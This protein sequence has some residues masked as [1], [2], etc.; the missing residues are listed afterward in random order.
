MN[1]LTHNNHTITLNKEAWWDTLSRFIDVLKIN[2]FIIDP[3]GQLILPPDEGRFGGK[4]FFDPSLKNEF[5]TQQGFLALFQR[6]EGM[7]EHKNRF[8]LYSYALP[9][10][11]DDKNI[12]G[13]LIVG[14]IFISKKLPSSDYETMAKEFGIQLQDL[15]NIF[16][17]IRIVSNIMIRSILDL[18]SQVIRDNVALKTKENE[19]N[20]LKQQTTTQWPSHM[21][22]IAKEIYSTVRVDE[23]LATLLD[24]ALKITQTE[25]G[26]ILLADKE[27]EGRMC[28]KV[29]RG[30]NSTIA[31]KTEITIGDG[32]C[33]LVAQENKALFIKR[34]SPENRIK[35]LLKRPHIQESLILPL[36]KHKKVLGVMTLNSTSSTNAIED[37]LE[38]IKRLSDFI[39]SAI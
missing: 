15:E 13:Y 2:I 3:K 28:I 5:Y 23:L 31:E 37:N 39:I 32:L 7:L 20:T 24:V 1:D 6:K 36:A 8:D 25:S 18:L 34:D 14:P 4:L 29:S 10:N 38:N 22:Q 33:G 16:S 9:I 30:I 11:Q 19:L 21:Q 12:L 35:H 17:E 26:S 27:R